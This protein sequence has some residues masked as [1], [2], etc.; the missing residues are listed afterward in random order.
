MYDSV[1]E[2]ELLSDEEQSSERIQ[3]QNT[4]QRNLAQQSFFKTKSE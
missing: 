1:E 2:S 3:M 4:Y